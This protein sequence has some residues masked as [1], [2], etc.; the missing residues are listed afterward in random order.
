MYKCFGV[1]LN[2]FQGISM[3]ILLP[4]REWEALKLFNKSLNAPKN[5][6]GEEH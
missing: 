3:Y 2:I 4:H 1:G 6:L 5:F